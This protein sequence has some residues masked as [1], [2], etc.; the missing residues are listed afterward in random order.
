MDKDVKKIGKYNILGTLGQGAMGLVYRG[1]DPLLGRQVAIKVITGSDVTEE[2]K[3][4]FIHEARAVAA[5]DHA[6][7]V[8]VY[9][10][11]E[12]QG[13]PYI[14][15]ELLVGEDLKDYVER[16]KRL[17]VDEAV[18]ILIQVCDGLAYAHARKIVHRDIKPANIHVCDDGR[19]KVMDFGVAKM[20]STN[21]TATGMVI[22][23]PD[24][25]SPEQIQGKAV[26]QRT[27]IFAAGVVF[28]ELLSRSKPFTADSITS[29]IYNVVFKEPPSFDSLSL[30]VP[31]EIE[32]IIRKAMAKD[33]DQRYQDIS[34]MARD[35]R[36]WAGK[37]QP[38]AAVS[39]AAEVG[40]E[41]AT[42]EISA[43]DVAAATQA[44]PMPSPG[45]DT[46]QVGESKSDRAGAAPAAG[47]VVGGAPAGGA[48][49]SAAAAPAKSKL[50]VFI[51]VAAAIGLIAAGWFF[52]G[53]KGGGGGGS[54]P[55]PVVN[56][57]PVSVDVLI[58]PWAHI[59]S[60][61]RTD[62]GAASEIALDESNT[63]VRLSLPPGSY[64][65][66]VS[67]PALDLRDVI[68]FDVSPGSDQ[69]IR[70]TLSGFEPGSAISAV[71][72]SES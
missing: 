39:A 49:A 64:R 6:N 50:P 57:D 46:V 65:M 16:K 52:L 14:A 1:E 8:V 35:L 26:D 12:E 17:P 62:Q 20:E 29:V 31:A 34:E 3:Q 13:V 21:L 59:D 19:V 44:G 38:G 9:D 66:E 25:M 15:M 47:T 68:S 10:L 67:N 36:A 53:P 56:A 7:I 23:T 70:R 51:G 43:S 41:D 72:A 55:P 18:D 11:G 45:A 32:R 60:L 48:G 4:R 63:P 27:D 2:M 5:I 33:L 58:A 54:D 30:D 42:T 24:Y 69:L 61:Q 40:E 28:Y 71:L 37:P 22:G